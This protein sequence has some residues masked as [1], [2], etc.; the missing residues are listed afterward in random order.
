[1]NDSHLLRQFEDCSF[2]FEQ[3]HHE[4]HVRI[5]FLYLREHPLEDAVAS[6]P[7]TGPMTSPADQANSLQGVTMR[8]RNGRRNMPPKWCSHLQRSVIVLAPDRS[9]PASARSHSKR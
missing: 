9:F 2:P 8:Y 6:R 1:M 7:T 3:W 4:A 5:A